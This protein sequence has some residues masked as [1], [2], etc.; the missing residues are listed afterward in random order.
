[1]RAYV[2]FSDI[3]QSYFKMLQ[4]MLIGIYNFVIIWQNQKKVI[5]TVKPA[6]LKVRLSLKQARTGLSAILLVSVCVAFICWRD[7]N[8]ETTQKKKKLGNRQ[9]KKKK[10]LGNRQKILRRDILV[11]NSNDP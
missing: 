2:R 9:K 10:K 1:M 11:R 8:S 3:F 6:Q 4:Y 5:H 7:V